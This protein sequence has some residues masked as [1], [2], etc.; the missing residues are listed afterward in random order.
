MAA[1]MVAATAGGEASVTVLGSR[2]C[3]AGNQVTITH[4]RNFECKPF[5]RRMST[6]RL[7]VVRQAEQGLLWWCALAAAVEITAY[8]AGRS[9]RTIP[10][11]GPVVT[12]LCRASRA[13]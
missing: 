7:T 1:K 13:R 6:Q 8:Y 10:G 9:V 12:T 11:P 3:N 4:L 5:V 2:A